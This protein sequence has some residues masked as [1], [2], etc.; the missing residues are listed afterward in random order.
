[1][2]A[3]MADPRGSGG[4]RAAEATRGPVDLLGGGD[5]LRG[6]TAAQGGEAQAQLG[7]A[8]HQPQRPAERIDD[9]MWQGEGETRIGHQA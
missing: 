7:E 8:E 4:W 9:L 3:G 1:M 6:G 2:G 5:F